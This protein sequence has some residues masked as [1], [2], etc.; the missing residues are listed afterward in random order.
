[1]VTSTPTGHAFQRL[2]QVEIRSIKRQQ[3]R[4]ARGTV[5]L[6]TGGRHS[7][8]RLQNLSRRDRLAGP[9]IAHDGSILGL[10]RGAREITAVTGTVAL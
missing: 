2:E 1:M 6:R 4:G 5:E 3:Q 8:Q 10:H 7:V 9:I